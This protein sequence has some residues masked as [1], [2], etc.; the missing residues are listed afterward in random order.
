MSFF[1][2]CYIIFKLESPYLF[3]Y[4]TII[5]VLWK[6][7]DK[8]SWLY[9]IKFCSRCWCFS[10]NKWRIFYVL[11]FILFYISNFYFCSNYTFFQIKPIR[12]TQYTIFLIL[13]SNWK[14]C[15]IFLKFIRDKRLNFQLISGHFLCSFIYLVSY[16][17]LSFLY[18][19][20]LFISIN[21]TWTIL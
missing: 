13:F 19:T 1:L 3:V 15:K 14:A 17:Q 16:F 21:Y 18:Y 9:F 8:D 2:V 10:I 7:V 12:Y 4:I 11:S 20:Y 5:L 6:Y